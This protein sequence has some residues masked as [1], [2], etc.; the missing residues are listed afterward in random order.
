MTTK[1][2]EQQDFEMHPDIIW[3]LILS[4]GDGPVKAM[5]ELLMN[6]M[7][8]GATQVDI[9]WTED[10][11]GITDNGKGFESRQVIEKF[12][13]TFGTPHEKGDALFGVFRI[14][15][16]QIMGLAKNDWRTG[17]FRMA[18]DVKQFGKSYLLEEDLPYVEGCAITGTWYTKPSAL[19]LI[20]DIE[21]FRT[22]CAYLPL[23]VMLN[24]QPM[25]LVEDNRW[26]RQDDKAYF[27]L[28]KSS[29][30]LKVYNQGVF[31]RN[32]AAHDVGIGGV[33]TTKL[34][35]TVNMARNDVLTRECAVWAH[36]Q[37]VLTEQ[38]NKVDAAG[39]VDGGK[40]TR[41]NRSYK[42][43][44]LLENEALDAELVSRYVLKDRLFVDVAGK[45]YSLSGLYEAVTAEYGGNLAL[46]G[47]S[48]VMADKIHV[49]QDA[50]VL[51]KESVT[52]AGVTNIYDLL[53]RIEAQVSSLIKDETQRAELVWFIDEL[54]EAVVDINELTEGMNDRHLPVPDCKLTAQ[55]RTI[56]QLL[57]EHQ[58]ILL[59]E[60]NKQT[61]TPLARRQI[62]VGTSETALGWTDARANIWL[63][64]Q[65]FKIS[66]LRTYVFRHFLAIATILVHEYMHSDS[67]DTATHGPQFY[68]DFERTTTQSD[69][70]PLFMAKIVPAYLAA[71]DKMK[72]GDKYEVE[73]FVALAAYQPV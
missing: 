9:T 64:R 72:A 22:N 29:Y 14:G 40:S 39:Q 67:G 12:F 70:I 8:A 62:H 53:A 73:R 54:N 56:L 31:V 17:P 50:L 2:V 38:A 44:Q 6:S 45:T 59:A 15:R 11:F 10:G 61:N 69:A 32:F 18:V 34:P 35:L 60:L 68:E 23:N 36:I 65:H 5:Q 57:N 49:R 4:Q 66:G 37:A 1:T 7:D 48:K 71:C 27:K 3:S 21:S 25:K 26:T 33:V 47:N 30:Y 13:E 20:E 41:E 63:E 46:E 24:G 52:D 43:T 51:S 42:L 16:G 55:E 19:Q 28:S 58:D